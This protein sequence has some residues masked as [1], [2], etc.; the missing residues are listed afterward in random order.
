LYEFWIKILAKLS[1]FCCS[2]VK[3]KIMNKLD[4][5]R[6]HLRRGKVYRRGG[7]AKWSAAMDRHLKELVATGELVKLS[8]ELYLYPKHTAFGKA[9]AVDTE[10]ARA[11]LKDNRFLLVSPNAYNALGVGTTQLYNEIVVY[12][13]KRHGRFNLGGRM[14]EFRRKPYFPKKL[15]EEF[16]LVDLV[17]N[18]KQLAE[19]PEQI[20]RQV[21]K[22]ALQLN[23]H[24]LR[25]A[26]HE[27]GE[28]HT[29][30]FFDTIVVEDTA[31]F[32]FAKTEM[33]T[34]LKYRSRDS[35]LFER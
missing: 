14:F 18:L 32:N 8:A 6:K 33:K 11:F 29:R 21:K 5:L 9:P 25:R 15:T 20:Q 30:K 22:K 4:E 17:N 34:F 19:E 26:T 2:I 31:L 16:L 27:Y 23:P 7:L 12:N 1:I 35:R 10:L 24:T 13:H 28:V 3:G